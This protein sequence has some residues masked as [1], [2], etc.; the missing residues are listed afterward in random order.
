MSYTKEYVVATYLDEGDL[1]KAVDELQKDGI[2]I[3]EVYTPY[4]VHGLDKALDMKDTRL[5]IAGFI[6]GFIGLTLMLV[7]ISW[8]SLSDWPT[9]YGGKPLWSLPAFVPILFESTVLS[10]AVGMVFTFLY[11]CKLSP[12][13]KK[14]HFS[15]KATD[16]TF[17]LVIKVEDTHESAEKLLSRLKKLKPISAEKQTANPDWWIGTY[18]KEKR[19]YGENENTFKA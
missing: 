14:H 1:F 3:D 15:H 13:V 17:T 2:K 10:A 9:N 7:F 11:I 18:D 8:I 4:P 19:L 6:Y 5:H 12:F 16:D